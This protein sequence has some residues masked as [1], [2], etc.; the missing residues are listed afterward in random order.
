MN[1]TPDIQ[2]MYADRRRS[3]EEGA[4]RAS[5]DDAGK[6]TVVSPSQKYRI[7]LVHLIGKDGAVF[8]R[9]HVI[10]TQNHKEI[11]S[12]C[13]PA[14]DL[15][16]LWVEGH[17]TGEDY[18][19]SGEDIHGVTVVRLGDGQR[20]DRF[21]ADTVVDSSWI[22]LRASVSPD[23]RSLAVEGAR[24]GRQRGLRFFDFA[25]PEAAEWIEYPGLESSCDAVLEWTADGTCVAVDPTGAESTWSRPSY[26]ECLEEWQRFAQHLE[27]QNRGLPQDLRMNIR[28]LTERLA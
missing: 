1:D 3:V 22:W 17:A 20:W 21:D 7:D 25:E 4:S 10:N 19:I 5:E 12:I 24:S 14:D 13:R 6:E 26:T 15:P 9:G 18:L 23:G 28:L 11:T 8:V 16:V 27:A 2:A